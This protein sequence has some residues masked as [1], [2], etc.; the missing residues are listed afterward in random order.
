MTV[1]VSIANRSGWEIDRPE[2]ERVL[3]AVFAAERVGA[4]DVGLT[5]VDPAEMAELNG[6]HRG[7][8]VPTD[9]L[10]F[11]IDGADPL[12]D[13]MPAQLGDIV[14]CPAVAAEQGTPMSTL[15]VHGGLHLLGYDHEIDD[16]A[17][18]DR[19]DELLEEVGDVAVSA[20][21]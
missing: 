13:G 6:T 7:K 12:D 1:D 9:V 20:R 2:A 16:G 19:Q 15:I 3:Q 18:L 14:V 4:G 17:M 10:S 11:P 8:P 5:L 21:Q